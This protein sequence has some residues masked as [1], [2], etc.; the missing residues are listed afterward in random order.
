MEQEQVHS[1][2]ELEAGWLVVMI[3][4][5]D[6]RK[7]GHYV[8]LKGEVPLS[9][10]CAVRIADLQWAKVDRKQGKFELGME[11]EARILDAL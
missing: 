11:T 4:W 2:D 6:K 1:T 10:H 7:D 5:F 9:V 8:L 3:R